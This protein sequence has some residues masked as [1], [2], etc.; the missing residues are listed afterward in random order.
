VTLSAHDLG[1]LLDV[2]AAPFESPAS[3]ELY[4]ATLDPDPQVA[5]WATTAYAEAERARWLS[6]VSSA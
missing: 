5:A 6:F 1:D 3:W 2:Y 4:T